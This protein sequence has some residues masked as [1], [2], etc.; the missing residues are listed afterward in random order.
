MAKQNNKS[1]LQ[2]V[3]NNKVIFT[4]YMVLFCL[5]SNLNQAENILNWLLNL[6]SLCQ[7][8]SAMTKMSLAG[9]L[10]QKKKKGSN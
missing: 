10:M 9:I 1:E 3:K 2:L 7:L 5:K 4:I 8:T 6:D